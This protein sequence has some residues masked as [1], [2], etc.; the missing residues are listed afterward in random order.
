MKKYIDH[1]EGGRELDSSQVSEV[2]QL[3][4]DED[5]DPVEKAQF[6]EVF[7]KKGETAPEIAL[8]VSE[9]LERAVD[10]EVGP[11]SLEQPTIDVCGTGGDKLNLFN[12]NRLLAV[13]FNF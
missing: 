12:Q 11:D 9:L 4:V 8:F 6:L 2:V 3:L 10:P 13:V 1:V 7:A 5:A